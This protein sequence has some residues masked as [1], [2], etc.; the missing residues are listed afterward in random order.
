MKL[1]L[2]VDVGG[3][4]SRALITTVD[5]TR[6]GHG[7]AGAGNPVAVTPEVARANVSEA[8]TA[9]LSDMDRDWT[10][11][12]A[13]DHPR[14]GQTR[15]PAMRHAG[16]IAAAVVGA[17]GA[18][19]S[20]IFHKLLPTLGLDCPLRVVGDVVV[21]FAA[22]S[23]APRGTV[24]IAGTGA[25]AARVDGFE[26]VRVADGL[27]WLLGDLGSGFWL[28]RKAASVT[29]KALSLRTKG[30]LIEAISSAIGESDPD[31]FVIAVH[32]RP[33]RELAAL[34]PIVSEAALAGDPLALSIVDEAA[35]HL[36]TTVGE[37]RAPGETEP[38]VL[39]GSVLAHSEPIRSRVA[40]RLMELWPAAEVTFAAPAEIGAARL[41]RRCLI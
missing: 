26:E 11:A 34:A 1:V 4:A 21:A 41:A 19:G 25:A 38:I 31:G 2:G 22:G 15:P 33:P 30:F 7:R 23:T 40:K 24:L 36:V 8:I 6:V 17:A 5:G 39:S 20:D 18:A 32:A 9:A 10:P 28:G 16:K 12:R 13:G 14:S 3:T 37:I 35:G 29:A 27:G